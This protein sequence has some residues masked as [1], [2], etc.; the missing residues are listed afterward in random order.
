MV[1]SGTLYAPKSYHK[2]LRVKL[3]A[4]YSHATLEYVDYCPG[5]SPLP[6]SLE[7]CPPNVAPIFHSKDG[8]ILFDANA[9]AYF[10]GDKKIRGGEQEHF[11]TQWANFTDQVLM[12]SIASWLYP[13][14]GATS[15]NKGQVTK[16]QENMA[17]AMQFMNDFLASRTYFVGESVTQADLTIFS[18]MEMLFEHLLD[19]PSR[20]PYAHLVRW[21]TTIANQPEIIK[22]TGHVKLC[23]KATVFDPKKQNQKVKEKKNPE[24]AKQKKEDKPKPPPKGD[25]GDDEEP[26]APKPSKNPFIEL[27]AGTFV[28]DDFKKCYSNEDIKTVA[29]PFFWEKFDPTTDSIYLCEYNYPDE[30]SLVFMSSNLIAGMFQRLERMQKYSFAVMNVYGENNK[31]SIGGLWVWRGTGLAFDL[32]PDLQTDFE[33]YKWTKLDHNAPETKKRVEEYMLHDKNV[34]IDGRQIADYSVFK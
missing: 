13:I 2:A 21:Y 17:K 8:T 30:L 26:P 24:P 16:A 14:L 29:I 11:V 19:E 32:S 33:S 28:Y 6:E 12:P 10:I 1:V 4:A 22:I 25:D 18:A 20:K 9:I 34:K 7:N 15:Y 31:S 23:E 5:Q 3:A 27:P